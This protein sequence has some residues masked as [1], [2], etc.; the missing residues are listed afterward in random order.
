MML[1]CWNTD[2]SKKNLS[3]YRRS[4]AVVLWR[5]LAIVMRT[6]PSGSRVSSH[7]RQVDYHLLIIANYSRRFH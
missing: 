7:R 2:K 5:I 3:I 1:G 6:I 4:I